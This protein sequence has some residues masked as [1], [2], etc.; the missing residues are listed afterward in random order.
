M[1]AENVQ[2]IATVMADIERRTRQSIKDAKSTR[3]DFRAIPVDSAVP[4]L[5]ASKYHAELLALTTGHAAAILDLH[6]RMTEDAKDYG[7]DVPAL[8][9]DDDDGEI[10]PLGGG[11]R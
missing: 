9:G 3:A 1:S 11:D 6:H 8:P 10:G 4:V 2:N 5:M 7:I